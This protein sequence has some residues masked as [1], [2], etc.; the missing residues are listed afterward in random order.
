MA[1]ASG[2]AVRQAPLTAYVGVL[3]RLNEAHI[4]EER[5]GCEEL[6]VDFGDSG[7]ELVALLWGEGGDVSDGI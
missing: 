6:F 7:G 5:W 2:Y 4:Y 1:H 3:C